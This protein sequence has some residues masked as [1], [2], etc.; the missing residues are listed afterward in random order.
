MSLDI[1]HLPFEAT[2]P[3]ETLHLGG[4]QMTNEKR[5]LVYDK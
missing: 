4:F 2:N 3:H 5:Q 1:F